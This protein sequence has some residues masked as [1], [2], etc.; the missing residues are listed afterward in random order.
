PGVDP[1]RVI[2]NNIHEI[3]EVL[4][5]EAA[6]TAIVKEAKSVLKEQGI[7]VDVRHLLLL[8]D[9][10]TL[11]G[12]VQQV[13]RH[14]VIKLKSSVL[15]RAA[16]EVS[17]QTLLDAAVKGE[18]DN[19]KGNVERIL[20]GKEIPVGTGTVSLLMKLSNLNNKTMV[21]NENGS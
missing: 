15:A 19:L 5:I 7:D 21:G 13:G 2:T 4:G 18:I 10:M 20:I 12:K 17:T 14:G 6:R 11:S 9:M 1:K 8:A 16:F 3:A